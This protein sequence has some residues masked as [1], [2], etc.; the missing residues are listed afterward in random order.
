[1]MHV[2][3]G[4]IA[5]HLL[6]FIIEPITSAWIRCENRNRGDMPQRWNPSDV[7]LAGVSAGIE[8]IIFVFLSGGDIA[9]DCI[10]GALGLRSAC[11]FSAARETK[12]Y[13]ECDCVQCISWFHKRIL[14]LKSYCFT[15]MIP[16]V[17]CE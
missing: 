6:R 7:N 11:L 15:V 1:M 8:Q 17:P 4:E 9:G 16:L 2:A 10:G 13:D 3:P 14:L 5:K 12:R